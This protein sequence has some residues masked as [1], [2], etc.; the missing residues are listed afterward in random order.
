M[1]DPEADG[2]FLSLY[3]KMI[4]WDESNDEDWTIT[5]K[6]LVLEFLPENDNQIQ[7]LI[8]EWKDQLRQFLISNIDKDLINYT[9]K[10]DNQT[11]QQIRLIYLKDIINKFTK[12]TDQLTETEKIIFYEFKFLIDNEMEF[13]ETYY[14]L[15]NKFSSIAKELEEKTTTNIEQVEEL[16]NRTDEAIKKTNDQKI[17]L[18]GLM[19]SMLSIFTFIGINISIVAGI[20]QANAPLNW[21]TAVILLISNSIFVLLLIIVLYFLKRFFGFNNKSIIDSIKNNKILKR[22]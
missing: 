2:L 21:I 4:D 12:S 11:L 9:N 19:A 16:N 10:N 6:N 17:D 22:K 5:F 20:I 14:F 18:I 7:T 1:F 3:R 8:L 15:F 13:I